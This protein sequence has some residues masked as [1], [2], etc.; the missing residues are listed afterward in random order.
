[1]DIQQSKS[2]CWDGDSQFYSSIHLY[3]YAWGLGVTG[4]IMAVIFESG[5]F[6]SFFAE[7]KWPVFMLAISFFMIAL[8]QTLSNFKIVT[9]ALLLLMAI[10]NPLIIT[11]FA[12]AG[13]LTYISY[14]AIKRLHK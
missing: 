6:P 8:S 7:I 3:A 11:W 4:G 10:N 2:I 9:F 13:I 5:I 14:A 1:M 12:Y